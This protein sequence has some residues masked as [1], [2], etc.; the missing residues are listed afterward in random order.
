MSLC[1]LGLKKKTKG[2]ERERKPKLLS[3]QEHLRNA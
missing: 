1:E 3:T 2:D